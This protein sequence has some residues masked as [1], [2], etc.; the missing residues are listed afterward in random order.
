MPQYKN[1]NLEQEYITLGQLLK[2]A[3]VLSSGGE[4]KHFLATTPIRVN[5][6]PEQR[7]GR[8]LH[9]GDLILIEGFEGIRLES[10]ESLS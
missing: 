6:V 8:K 2:Y 3:D 10:K 7:R 5:G 4:V 1:I 9:V